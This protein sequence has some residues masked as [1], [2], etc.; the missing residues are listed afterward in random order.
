MRCETHKFFLSCALYFLDSDKHFEEQTNAARDNDD[1]V[2]VV[3]I[4]HY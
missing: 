2:D 3:E 1:D 4:C